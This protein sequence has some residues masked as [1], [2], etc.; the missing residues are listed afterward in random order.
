VAGDGSQHCMAE[1]L[2][3]NTGTASNHMSLEDDSKIQMSPQLWSRLLIPAPETLSSK[4]LM[5]SN[6]QLTKIMIMCVVS[7]C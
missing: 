4:Q 2:G 1:D 6:F 7:N 5:C 3:L